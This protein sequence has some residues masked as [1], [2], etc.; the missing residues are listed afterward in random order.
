MANNE[1]LI[2][3]V[4]GQ[5]YT[6]F[7]GFAVSVGMELL[8]SFAVVQYTQ[9][10]ANTFKFTNGDPATVSIGSDLVLTGYVT[11]Y[12]DE[13]WTVNAHNKSFVIKSKTQDLA[14]GQYPLWHNGKFRPSEISGP[15]TFKDLATMLCEP[16]NIG[17]N[18]TST[19][20]TTLQAVKVTV[21]QSVLSILE[22]YAKFVGV[23]MMDSPDG[24]LKICDVCPDQQPTVQPQGQGQ[25]FQN[26]QDPSLAPPQNNPVRFVNGEWTTANPGAPG[27][28]SFSKSWEDRFSDYYVYNPYNIDWSIT[29]TAAQASTLIA[30]AQ[31]PELTAKKR[32]KP[33]YIQTAK[34]DAN[35]PMT[36]AQRLA[37]WEMN[38][39]MGRSEKY[40]LTF[41]GWRDGAGTLYLPNQM[42]QSVTDDNNNPITMIIA[43]ATL[44]KTLDGGTTTDVLLMPRQAFL[45]EP[46]VI[47]PPLGFRQD[48]SRTDGTDTS[49]PAPSPTMG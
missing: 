34:Y 33:M 21:G 9:K 11:Y 3:K 8:P 2:I 1:G 27:A 4:N 5:Q 46:F 14:D 16:F 23:I 37:N 42:A 36:Y 45:V 39:R 40:N 20:N 49:P 43:G 7:K 47:Q 17:V 22:P 38:R 18:Y 6:N 29:P 15:I 12:S 32:F 19:I 24:N 10:D 31:D 13:T 28:F 48:Q 41:T 26:N 25:P 44:N 35:D 30:H